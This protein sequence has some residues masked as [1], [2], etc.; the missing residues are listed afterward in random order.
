MQ[1]AEA[2]SLYLVNGYE[3]D[4]ISSERKAIGM[5]DIPAATGTLRRGRS[6]GEGGVVGSARRLNDER[7]LGRLYA[8]C[9]SDH[10]SDYRNDRG[11]R[12]RT[13]HGG[14]C[15]AHATPGK[16]L[17]RIFAAGASRTVSDAVTIGGVSVA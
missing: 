14:H 1:R 15:S 4:E 6:S 9:W 10:R 2:D 3:G 17:S 13:P 5:D 12:V 11:A 16:R 8:R 7:T